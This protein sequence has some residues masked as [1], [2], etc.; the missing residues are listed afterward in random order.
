[1]PRSTR[2]RI[3]WTAAVLA[4]VAL[5]T[6][7]AVLANAD[8]LK[9][10]KNKVEQGVKSAS[11]D[12]ED[13]SRA[14]YTATAKLRAAKNQLFA[15]QRALAKTRGELTTARILDAQMQAKLILAEAAL[16]KARRELVVGQ[17]AVVEQRKAIGRLAVASFQLGDPG[18]LRMSVLL[19]GD[20]PEEI[21]T[22]LSTIDSVMQSADS[23]LA[24]LE[25]KEALLEVQRKRVAAA[26]IIVAEQRQEAAVNLARKQALEEEAVTN[27]A[28]VAALVNARAN[29]AHL[30]RSARLADQRKLRAL[31]AEEAR[32]QQLII[33]RAR[34]HKGGFTG[35]SNGFLYR[36]VP[37]P[38]TSPYGYRRHPIYG[39]YGLHDGVDFRAPCG[40]PMHAGAKGTVISEYYSDV[41]G[42]RLILDVGRV[43]GR[44]MTLIYNHIS[45]YRAHT[46]NR[47]DRGEVVAYSGTTGWSTACHLHFTVMIDGTAV[48]PAKYL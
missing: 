5:A 41:W 2:R 35:S 8:D 9:D 46:G 6:G 7:P 43:N 32:L 4:T 27:R 18:M 16:K 19:N 30:A 10:K 26:K 48:D 12:L 42:N 11:G 1:M 17:A 3:R 31:R 47:V 28:Q 33:A 22:Q 39:Y 24:D 15:A 29:A 21:S 14:M 20:S 34:Q 38:I 36:P 40:T 23:M 13:S 25:A 45:S 44:A 37:G